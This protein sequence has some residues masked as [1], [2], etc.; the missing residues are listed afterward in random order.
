MNEKNIAFLKYQLLTQFK[1]RSLSM[2]IES[3]CYFPP[4][5]SFVKGKT[6]YTW[7]EDKPEHI[8]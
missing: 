3:L 7:L 5:K 6:C 8:I 4:L 2:G 1:I